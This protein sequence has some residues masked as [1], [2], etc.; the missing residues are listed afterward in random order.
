MEPDAVA[1]SVEH[2]LP[3]WKVGSLN[4]R[5]VKSVIFKIDMSLSILALIIIRIRQ[6]LVKSVSG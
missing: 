6:G 2:R 1:K 5:Q 4:L 3:V